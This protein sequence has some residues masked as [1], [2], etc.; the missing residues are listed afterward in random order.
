MNAA[1]TTCVTLDIDVINDIVSTFMIRTSKVHFM[2]IL[3]ADASDILVPDGVELVNVTNDLSERDCARFGHRIMWST[4]PSTVF[5]FPTVTEFRS[6]FHPWFGTP[7]VY[8]RMIFFTAKPRSQPT[9]TPSPLDALYTAWDAMDS[10]AQRILTAS[11]T[12][13]TEAAERLEKARLRMGEALMVTA[14]VA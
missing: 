5:C 9:P 14:K 12:Q 2:A 4:D 7:D 11:P 3:N 6:Y 13:M 8:N 1:L 10:A